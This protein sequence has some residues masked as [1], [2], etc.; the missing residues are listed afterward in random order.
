M[1]Y[2]PIEN[3]GMVPGEWQLHHQGGLT[4]YAGREI[5]GTDTTAHSLNSNQALTWNPSITGVKSEDSTLLTDQGLEV[6]TRTGNWPE[7]EV[8]VAPGRLSRPDIL[9]K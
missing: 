4:G 6:L 7:W 1:G 3:Y 8:E 9:I 2:Q 5:F